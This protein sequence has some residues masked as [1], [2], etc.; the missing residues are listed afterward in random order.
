M[1][2]VM[3]IQ[4][5]IQDFY[6]TRKRSIPYGLASIATVLDKK[7]ISVTI[8]DCLATKKKRPLQFPENM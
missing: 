8:L 4:P 7:N 1:T 6:F 5:P 3:L 2:D